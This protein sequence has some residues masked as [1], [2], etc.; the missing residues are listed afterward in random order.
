MLSVM[1][2]AGT[3]VDTLIHTTSFLRENRIGNHNTE[4][5]M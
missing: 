3:Q 1:E 4:L 5:E 2:V